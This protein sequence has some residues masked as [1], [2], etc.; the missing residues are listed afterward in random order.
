MSQKFYSSFY[1]K[2]KRPEDLPWHREE[3]PEWLSPAVAKRTKPGRFLD[4]GCGTGVYSAQLAR[5][6]WD[7]TAVDFTHE[8]LEM[9]RDRARSAGVKV[10]FVQADVLTW[11]GAGAFDIVMDSGCLH[12]LKPA[13]RSRYKD[14]IL[15]WLIPGAD[16][17]L[18]HFGRR[19]FLDWRPMGPRRRKRQEIWAELAPQ[20]SER[21]YKEHLEKAPLPIGPTFQICEYW[22]QKQR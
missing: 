4:L 5:K 6:G 20:F 1:S 19:H 18:I 9:A 11:E 22:F 7:V 13:D 3:M 12:S 15:K 2:A 14:Q 16:Y 10:N 8:A 21:D 17:I